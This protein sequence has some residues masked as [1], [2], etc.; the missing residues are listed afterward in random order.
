MRSSR[1]PVGVTLAL[2][3]L[4]TCSGVVSAAQG[5]STTS[6]GAFSIAGTL[7]P[8]ASNATA[9]IPLIAGWNLVALPLTQ[10]NAA[11]EAVLTAIAGQYDAVYGY[12]AC[13]PIDPWKKYDPTAPPFVN[14]LSSVTVEQGL[15]IHANVSTILTVTGTAPPAQMSIPLCAGANLIGYPSGSPVTLPDA[16]ASIAG[17]YDRVHS[18]DP[19]DAAD[20]WKTFDPG[21]P[22]FVNLTENDCIGEV[23]VTV[24]GS[25]ITAPKLNGIARQTTN[26]KRMAPIRTPFLPLIITTPPRLLNSP[27]RPSRPYRP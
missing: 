11:P 19:S 20:P 26:A 23:N 13:D 17:K 24:A 25:A 6:S 3:V 12:D 1:M 14:D 8:T 27:Y 9:T 18:Y 4:A 2:I 15:W 10:V 7:E 5:Y 22:S 16:L 21:A